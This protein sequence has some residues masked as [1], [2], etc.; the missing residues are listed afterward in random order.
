[1]PEGHP[2]EVDWAAGP[3]SHSPCHP[4]DLGGAQAT[5][6][7]D[8]E[9]ATSQYDLGVRRPLPEGIETEMLLS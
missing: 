4:A 2:S 7:K 1:M 6:L 5:Y 3:M 8:K 9:G